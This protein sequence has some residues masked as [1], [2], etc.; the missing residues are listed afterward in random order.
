M[1]FKSDAERINVLCETDSARAHTHTHTHTHKHI[2]THTKVQNGYKLKV[3]R[4]NGI[5]RVQF[6][7]LNNK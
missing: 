1:N 4:W 3:P 2:Y 6:A 5:N 7:S